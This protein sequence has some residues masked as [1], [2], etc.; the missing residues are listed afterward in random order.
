MSAMEEDAS[1]A[2]EPPAEE[3][4]ATAAEEPV[5]K[6]ARTDAGDDAAPAAAD[7]DMPPAADAPSAD[8][9]EEDTR[10]VRVVAGRSFGGRD[11]LWT[12]VQALQRKLDG[13]LAQGGD[14]FFLFALVTCHPGANEKLAPGVTSIG[15]D[16]NEQFPDTKSFFVER[17]DGSKAGFSARKCVD[18]LYPKEGAGPG[19]LTFG[20]VAMGASATSG[21]APA[22]SRPVVR[23]AHVRIDGLSGQAVQYGE[24]KDALTAFAAPRFVDLN[25]EE[26]F[27]I[28]RFDDAAGALKACECGDIEGAP[29]TIVVMAPEAEDAYRKDAD[30][31]REASRQTRGKGGKGGKGRGKGFGKG[32]Q[33]G[34][35]LRSAGR[36]RGRGRGKGRGRGGGRGLDPSMRMYGPN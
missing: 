16:V 11:E 2:V 33:R 32:R 24:I 31:K 1:A 18:E 35:G 12:Y 23:G 14:A 3:P 30:A 21:G 10:N 26:G 36:G 7:A 8:A 4:D 28:A 9:E 34:Q 13:G 29:V 15:Y 6:K 17:A 25:D 20:R 5:A 19:A 27:A 22:P